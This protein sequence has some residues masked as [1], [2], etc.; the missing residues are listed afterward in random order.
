MKKKYPTL[1]KIAAIIFLLF[2]SG[3]FS[4]TYCESRGNNRFTTGIRLVQFN[5]INNATPQEFNDYSD[6]TGISTTVTSGTS[7]GLTV[8][9]NTSGNYRIFAMAWIDWNQDGDFLDPG[10]AFILGN[11]NN[12]SNGTTSNSPLD[13]LIPTTALEGSTRMRISAKWREYPDPCETNFDGEVEDYTINII[14]SITTGTISPTSYC[15]GASV[16]I[17]YTTTGTFNA[18]NIFTA[19]LSNATGGFGSPVPIGTRSS[20]AAGDYFRYN[21]C[22]YSSRDGLQNKSG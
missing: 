15:A 9:L 3:A 22:W 6:F 14:P 21:P 16:S 11:T 8:S 1:K 19:Q 18:G 10:E 2:S 4:Q 7:Y 20:T 17:P 5:T 12:N 13:I